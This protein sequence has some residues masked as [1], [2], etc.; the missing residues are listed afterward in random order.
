MIYDSP[1]GRVIPLRGIRQ[2]DPLS[3]YIFILCSEILSG[4][5][6][7]AQVEGNLKKI[8]VARGSLRIN[9]LLFADDTMFSCKI[10]NS[11]IEALN[12]ILCDYERASGQSINKEKSA[13]NFSKK[14]PQELR[15]KIKQ[16]L[17]INKEGGV[18]KYLGLPEHFG[19]KKRDLFTS[20]VDKIKQKALSWSSKFLSS[21]GKLVF[22]KSVLSAMP[23][24][25]MTCFK[26]PFSLCKRIQSALT[27][28]WWDAK[29]GIKKMAWLAWDKL[30]KAKMDGGLGFRDIQCFNDAMLAKLSWRILEEP[31]CLLAK[32]L[33]GKHCTYSDFMEC[34]IPNSAS[35]GWRGILVGMDLLAKHLD[36]AI[37]NGADVC[38]WKDNWLSTRDQRSPMG[39]VEGK[40]SSLK[41][42]D[43]FHSNTTDWNRTLLQEILAHYEQ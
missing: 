39:P 17:Q 13:I 27:R 25:A 35:H 41:V 3:P 33:I 29:P 42:K 23:S 32:V 26:L 2:G 5:C 11:S 43:L 30:T 40:H 14:T 38:V 8:R 22:L 18:G 28:F 37:G 16:S 31:N 24:Y 4:L 12:K 6:K 36:W 20:I 19:R 15:E 10:N 34:T 21:A 1:R 7:K 9:H